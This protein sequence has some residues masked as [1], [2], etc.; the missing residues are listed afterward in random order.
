[1][2]GWEVDGNDMSTDE[3]PLVKHKFVYKP[4][5]EASFR[6]QPH[7]KPRTRNGEIAGSYKNRAKEVTVR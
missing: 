4:G 5:V 3:T 1:M 2:H 6:R 7:V